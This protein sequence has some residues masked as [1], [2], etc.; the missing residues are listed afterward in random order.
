MNSIIDRIA[1][2]LSLDR[3]YVKS[4]IQKSNF[5]YRRFT[6]PKQNGNPRVI[7]QASP[8]LKSLQYWVREKIL[9]FLPVSD[10]AFAYQ[11]GSSIKRHA[12]F[13]KNAYFIFHT[14]I[15]NYFPSIHDEMLTNILMEHQDRLQA[16]GMWFED[17]CDVVAKI[18]FR[19]KQLCIGTVS[20]PMISNIVAYKFDESVISYCEKQ[21]YRYSRYADDIYISG[22]SYIPES[23][24]EF[25]KNCLCSYGFRMNISKT[26]F[27]SKKSRRKITGLIITD[28]G[29]VSVG[30]ETR[31][32]I[33][34][35][36]YQCLVNGNGSP[37]KILGYLAYLKD[38]EP[39]T[40]NKFIIKYSTY[41]NG[42]V[43][44]VIRHSAQKSVAE[45]PPSDPSPDS[46]PSSTG[47]SLTVRV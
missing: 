27:K 3:I 9:K 24:E 14:D 28:T 47:V 29:Q 19:N 39:Q 35:M 30:M 44:S 37:S 20:S 34:G 31:K 15:K 40:Y 7:Y 13:H 32:K 22:N 23:T 17:I 1:C 11:T 33:K 38:V 41:C 21:G 5:Y 6:I 26:W 36:I 12:D 43:I 8:E 46:N 45:V 18:C 42:D 4:I 2:D 25:I 16:K 10:A